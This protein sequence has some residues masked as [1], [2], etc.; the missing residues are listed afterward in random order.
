M[1]KQCT[2]TTNTGEKLI[3]ITAKLTLKLGHIIAAALLV[4]GYG[5]GFS[6]SAL[7]YS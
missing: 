1:R 4:F 6:P 7:A 5:D 2:A 3:S